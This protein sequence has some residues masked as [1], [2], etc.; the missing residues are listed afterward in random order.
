MASFPIGAEETSGTKSPS[1]ILMV[2]IIGKY[3][4][5]VNRILVIFSKL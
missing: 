1:G 5:G 4:E 3:R 2:H